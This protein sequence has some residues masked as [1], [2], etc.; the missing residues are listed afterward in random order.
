MKLTDHFSLSEFACK[1]GCKGE[2][3]PEVLANLKLTAQMLEAVKAKV[4]GRVVHLNCG[5]RCPRHNK[6]VGGDEHS[7]H[8]VGKAADITVNGLKPAQ[9]QALLMGVPSIG[10]LGMYGSF[11]HVDIGPKRSWR[12]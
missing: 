11:T 2:E 10:G 12:G 6:A 9:V 3:R 5:Y 8:L 1:C 7:Q 4:G